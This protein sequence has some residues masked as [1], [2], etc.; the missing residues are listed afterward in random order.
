MKQRLEEAKEKNF[1]NV[2]VYTYMFEL[3]KCIDVSIY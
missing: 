3:Q 1:R 2:Y